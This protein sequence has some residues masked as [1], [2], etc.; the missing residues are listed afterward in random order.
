[1]WQRSGWGMPIPTVSGR[2]M[3][4]VESFNTI[5]AHVIEGPLK[6]AFLANIP[7]R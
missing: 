1:M 3:V 2:G 6:T 4:L 5:V 7:E